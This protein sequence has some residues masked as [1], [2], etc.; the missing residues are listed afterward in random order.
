MLSVRSS[1][2]CI[3]TVRYSYL[4][5]TMAITFPQ[6]HLLATAATNGAVVI[7]DILR[8]QATTTSDGI[9]SGGGEQQ[10]SIKPHHVYSDHRRTAY[11]V[12]C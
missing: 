10:R 8:A 11:K 4:V 2:S 9:H 6:D 1:I 7:W 3:T 5:R 12:S